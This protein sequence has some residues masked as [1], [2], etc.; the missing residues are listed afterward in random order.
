MTEPVQIGD[1]TLYQGDAL[2]LLPTLE[3][4]SVDAVIV[5]P[6]YLIGAH[7][8]GTARAK[9][10]TWAD[11]NNS[12]YWFSAWYRECLRLL[13]TETGH[14]ATF[15]NWRTQPLVICAMAAAG[16][17]ATS[18]LVWD[19]DWIGPA[20]KNAL[21][22]T[23]ELIVIASGKAA[24]IKN[25]SLNDIWRTKWMAGHS[26]ETLHP[27]EKPVSLL[28]QLISALTTES[29]CLLDP[30]MGSGTTGVAC[31]RLGRKFIGIEISEDYFK[32]ACQR[33]QEEY[34]RKRGTVGMFKESL[35]DT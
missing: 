31:V 28:M 5:D 7:S 29:S 11:L 9:S 1:C 6:P 25:R 30:M 10:G 4:G 8:I 15:C 23:Y 32:I 18:C 21:R 16:M 34:D 19:K 14:F 12:A 26:A 17:T 35:S 22:P 24:E 13:P 27:A 2:E 3:P 20:Y 33:I